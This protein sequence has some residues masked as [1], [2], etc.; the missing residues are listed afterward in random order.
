MI[1]IYRL[2]HSRSDEKGEWIG[3]EILKAES[4]RRELLFSLEV[5]GKGREGIEGYLM[6]NSN[7][8]FFL[9]GH[10]KHISLIAKSLEVINYRSL[11][12]SSLLSRHPPHIEILLNKRAPLPPALDIPLLYRCGPPGLELVARCVG[13]AAGEFWPSGIATPDMAVSGRAGT[14]TSWMVRER[15]P[16]VLRGCC[17]GGWACC[18]RR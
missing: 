8:A 9:P 16:H 6:S 5:W 1:S 3:L 15:W 12:A 17:G 7:G 13:G 10:F 18:C 2:H 11:A 14:P 4:R